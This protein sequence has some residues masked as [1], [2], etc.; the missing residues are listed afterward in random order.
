MFLQLR[1][2]ARDATLRLFTASFSYAEYYAYVLTFSS[3]MRLAKRKID[4]HFSIWGR[5]VAPDVL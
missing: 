2:C 4:A 3:V 1:A 5:E